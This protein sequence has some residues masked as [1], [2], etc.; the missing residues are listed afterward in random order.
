MST[1]IDQKVVEMRFD[2]KHFEDNVQTSM[3]TIDK[4]KD[5]LDFKGVDKNFDKI[6]KASKS[7]DMST[8]GRSVDAVRAK[9]SAL[10]VMSVTALA[11]ITNSAVNAGKK[12]VKSLSLDQL[13]AGM[14]K[15]EQKTSSV[16]T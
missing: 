6:S 5:K 9:F 11:N 14:S 2:N 4:L 12:L 10:E 13:T 16:H 3:G 7:V 8:L 15:Y 1:T